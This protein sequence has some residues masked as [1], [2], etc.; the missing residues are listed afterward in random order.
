M[1]GGMRSGDMTHHHDQSITL[2]SL[3]VMKTTV[4]RPVNLM[5]EDELE[6]L[7]ILPPRSGETTPHPSNPS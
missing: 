2:V 4:R 1:A 6:E 5:P 3:S 7:D